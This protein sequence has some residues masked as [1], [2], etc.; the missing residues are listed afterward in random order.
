MI[1]TPTFKFPTGFSQWS[2]VWTRFPNYDLYWPHTIFDLHNKWQTQTEIIFLSTSYIR[3]L[4]SYLMRFWT[5]SEL[6]WLLTEKKNDHKHRLLKIGHTSP[7]LRFKHICLLEIR[8]P[9]SSHRFLVCLQP[10]I[11]NQKVK[12]LC[13]SLTMLRKKENDQHKNFEV[14]SAYASWDNVSTRFLNNKFWGPH[15]TFDNQ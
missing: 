13:N 2:T 1:Y 11:T 6:K 4:R 14:Q 7:T 3:L 5:S 9:S 12:V 15:V 10:E 8:T